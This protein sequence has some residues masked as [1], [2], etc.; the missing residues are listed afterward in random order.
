MLLSLIR[1]IAAYDEEI[2]HLYEEMEQQIKKEKEQFLLKV[3]VSLLLWAWILLPLPVVLYSFCMWNESPQNVFHKR[4]RKNI[5]YL[6]ATFVLI[7]ALQ[8]Q[9]K[10]LFGWEEHWC[11]VLSGW[12]TVA[13]VNWK[14]KVNGTTASLYYQCCYRSNFWSQLGKMLFEVVESDTNPVEFCSL[15]FWGGDKFSLKNSKR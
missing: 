14:L 10:W 5:I 6:T 4:I 12:H 7:Q 13:A 9:T 11:P 15:C 8:L 3:S 1:K 2:Q